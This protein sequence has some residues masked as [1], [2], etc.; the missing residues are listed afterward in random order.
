MQ[1]TIVGNPE[2]R[3]VTSF[4]ET[5]QSIGYGSPTV[6]PYEAWLLGKD[7]PTIPRGSILKIDSPGE[8]WNVRKMLIARGLRSTNQSSQQDIEAILTATEDR[9]AIEH[10]QPWYA[11]Y[12][13]WLEEAADL[14][15]QQQPMSIM[16][17]PADIR[18]QFNKPQCQAWL[19]QHHVPVPF[20]LSAITGYDDLLHQMQQHHI[21][22]VFIKP[23]HASSAS[24]V[25]AFRKMGHRVQA[26]T[27]AEIVQSPPGI[28]LYNSLTIRTY[29]SEPEIAALINRIARENAGAEEWLP[30]ASLNNRYFDFRV[31]VIDGKARH[32]VIR[33]SRNIITNLH[34]GNQRGDLQEFIDRVGADKLQ[35]VKDLAEKAAA[36]FPGSLYMGID[37][38]L[39]AN[40]QKTFVLEINAFGDLLPGLLDQGETCYEAQIRAMI[41]RQYQATP[42]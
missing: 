22:R 13:N 23:A 3:R 2:N 36:C 38:L 24:G 40:F 19:Q 20:S 37:I 41:Q 39:S 30:K 26:I 18:L 29:T 27:S 15:R 1:L 11:G 25:I 9:G 33:S 32:T 12:C 14:I 8:N 35:Q 17:A 42:C 16:N 28:K 6:I 5:A 31:F 4:C 10:M 21:S 7:C 34:L